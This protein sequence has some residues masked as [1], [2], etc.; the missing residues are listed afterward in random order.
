MI[1][2]NL[3]FSRFFTALVS[4]VRFDATATLVAT[5]VATIVVASHSEAK[6]IIQFSDKNVKALLAPGVA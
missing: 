2:P 1:T 6:P 5:L 3:E 4:S